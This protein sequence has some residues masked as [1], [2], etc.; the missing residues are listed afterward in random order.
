MSSISWRELG[1]HYTDS[2]LPRQLPPSEVGP[3]VRLG[4]GA[5]KAY[6][7]LGE[8]V[9]LNAHADGAHYDTPP[10]CF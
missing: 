1:C 8:S 2:R 5:S 7:R 9:K 10:D 4:D 3:D 6:M